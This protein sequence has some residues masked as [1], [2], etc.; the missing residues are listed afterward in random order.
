M[1][2][3]MVIPHSRI[4]LVSIL[5]N[6]LFDFLLV[7][8]FGAPGLILATI[9]V[10]IFSIVAMLW[11][12]SKRLQGLNLHS[13]IQPVMG[14]TGASALSGLVAWGLWART[15]TVWGSQGFLLLLINLGI[16]A[17]GGFM[18]YGLAAKQLGIPEVQVFL[19]RIRAKIPFL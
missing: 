13:W 6:I 11:C 10:N 3:V 18:V 15:D 2:W 9:G 16:A 12:L 17:L 14:L 19:T 8:P 5:F 4:S 1:P 7:K